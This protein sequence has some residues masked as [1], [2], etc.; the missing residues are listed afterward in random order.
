MKTV[1]AKEIMKVALQIEEKGYALYKTLSQ[2]E[3]RKDTKK[4][5][6][7][8]AQEE[9]R[10]FAVLRSLYGDIIEPSDTLKQERSLPYL[11]RLMDNL[12]FDQLEER[13]RMVRT[14]NEGVD[15]AITFEK[16]TILFYIELYSILRVEDYETV[17]EILLMEKEHLTKL[18]Q[19]KEVLQLP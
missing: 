9:K 6:E 19:L 13:I 12:V 11:Q 16:D 2:D 18:F 14:E 7:H 5:F 3:S 4:V 15:I 8:L 10:H 1:S 17:N